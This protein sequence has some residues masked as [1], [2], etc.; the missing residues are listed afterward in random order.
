MSNYSQRSTV[1]WFVAPLNRLLSS[2]MFQR[3][4]TAQFQNIYILINPTPHSVIIYRLAEC[5]CG[6]S[7]LTTWFTK[8]SNREEW[9]SGRIPW[10]RERDSL[11]QRM[12]TSPV[13]DPIKEA[14]GCQWGGG[15]VDGRRPRCLR[16]C[17]T[18]SASLWERRKRER[19]GR[20][21]SF[22]VFFR[23]ALPWLIVKN[24]FYQLVSSACGQSVGGWSHYYHCGHQWRWRCPQRNCRSEW[25]N[26][27]LIYAL[28]LRYP[29][30]TEIHV[31]SLSED[32]PHVGKRKLKSSWRQ[33]P[34][35][36]LKAI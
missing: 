13:V 10:R 12:E 36:G 27:G 18:T 6:C 9:R 34:F 35:N 2:S 30:K 15:G 3:T 25:G 33:G 1:G 20:N 22:T 7:F 14:A 17:L 11:D 32:L 16:P 4:T 24:S 19:K 31:W 29:K 23:A 28:E 26:R 21:L 8:R 5:F